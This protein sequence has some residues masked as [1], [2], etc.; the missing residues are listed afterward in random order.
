M[1]HGRCTGATVH[2]GGR[3][4]GRHRYVAVGCNWCVTN[5]GAVIIDCAVDWVRGA[6]EWD[7]DPHVT[8]CGMDH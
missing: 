2:S 3:I 7:K 4:V 8:Y 1:R 5:I 6:K